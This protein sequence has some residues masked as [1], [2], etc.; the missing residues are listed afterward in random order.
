MPSELPFAYPPQRGTAEYAAALDAAARRAA[1]RG[2]P[3]DGRATLIRYATERLAAELGVP[4]PA[5]ARPRGTN[6]YGAPKKIP[7]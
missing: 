7:S 4:L 2:L 5:R 3:V 6:R 1:E